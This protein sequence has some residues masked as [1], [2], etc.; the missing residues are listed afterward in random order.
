MA[1]STSQFDPPL[2]HDAFPSFAAG[3]RV[4]PNLP[5]EML[6]ADG[7]LRPGWR[8][9]VAML[10]DLSPAERR[11]SWERAR[12]LIHENGVTHNVYG[13]PNGLDRPWS[14]DSIPLLI[15]DDEWQRVSR[16]LIQRAQ[17]LNRLLDD[18]HGTAEVVFNNILPAEMV[19]ANPFFLRPCAMN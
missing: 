1:R 9:F 4:Q 17:L 13:D 16:G 10:D 2:V 18:L 5:D 11:Q 8:R 15:P 6:D 12:R 19:W 3:Y 14:L 7:S